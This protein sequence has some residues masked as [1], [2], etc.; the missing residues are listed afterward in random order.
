MSNFLERL[1]VEKEELS[2]K[3]NSLKGF[4]ECRHDFKELS[5]SNQILLKEQLDSMQKYLNILVVRIELN[6]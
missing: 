5:E 4:V 2:T 3:L 6:S 1:V